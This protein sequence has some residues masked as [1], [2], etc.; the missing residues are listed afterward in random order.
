MESTRNRIRPFVERAHR[1]SG[2][3]LDEF[4][5]RPL[6]PRPPW[7]YET[8]A[9]ELLR[10]AKSVLDMGT[11]GGELLETLSASFRGRAVATEPWSVNAPVAAARL[12]PH[13]ISVVQCSSLQLPFRDASFDTVL[14]RHEE[15]DPA[16]VAR[17]LYARGSILT[18]QIG[19]D[20]W[21]ELRPFF[22][23]MQDFGDLFHR[24]ENGL[25]DYGLTIVQS[26]SHEWK[27]VYRGL[28]DIV[29]LLCVAP[30]EITEFDPLGGDLPALLA[31]EKALSTDQGIVLTESRFLLEA[32]RDSE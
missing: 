8:R 24:Y 32:K 17:V 16:E 26:R 4:A 29:F 27:A 31:A 2:W 3:R 25:K 28:G 22:P 9:A 14:N 18:Q 1:F 10:E 19:R 6:E 30:W 12:G 23:R 21:R 7:S 5:P 15:L 13:G 11:G 20:R